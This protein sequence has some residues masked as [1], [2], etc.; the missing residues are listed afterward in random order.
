MIWAF[1]VQ[2]GV[3]LSDPPAAVRLLGRT[4]A[5]YQLHTLRAKKISYSLGLPQQGLE[6]ICRRLFGGCG[7]T[8]NG[9]LGLPSHLCSLGW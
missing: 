8:T 2:L 1:S 6:E 5:T 9:E 3:T 7:C 4:L